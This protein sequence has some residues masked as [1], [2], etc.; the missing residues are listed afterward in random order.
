MYGMEADRRPCVIVALRERDSRGRGIE[1]RAHD[2]HA[3]TRRLRPIHDSI[4][5]LAERGEIHVRVAIVVVHAAMVTRLTDRMRRASMHSVATTEEERMLD[6]LI[7]FFYIFFLLLAF[8]F[9]M[10][11]AKVMVLRRVASV[12]SYST[13]QTPC[14]I[15]DEVVR[16]YRPFFKPKVSAVGEVLVF[17]EAKKIFVGRDSARCACEREY[18]LAANIRRRRRTTKAKEWWDA[19]WQP[20]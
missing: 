20:A 19:V 6:A 10:A 5:I 16:V 17:G 4:D 1:L 14:E 2:I 11:L 13:F 7:S 8:A 12:M 9:G 3:D 15:S 18:C